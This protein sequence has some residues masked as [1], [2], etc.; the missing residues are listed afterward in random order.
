LRAERATGYRGGEAATRPSDTHVPA[1]FV[2]VQQQRL[3][4]FAHRFRV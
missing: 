3:H 4:F 1:H 2:G